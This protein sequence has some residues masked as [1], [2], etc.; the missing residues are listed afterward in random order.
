M[1]HSQKLLLSIGLTAGLGLGAANTAFAS[2]IG[3]TTLSTQNSQFLDANTGVELAEGADVTIKSHNTS[4]NQNVFHSVYGIDAQAG[5]ALVAGTPVD[6][7]QACV[8]PAGS[9]AAAGQN[10][11]DQ[12][13]P[14]P[15]TTVARADSQFTSSL[16]PTAPGSINLAKNGLANPNDADVYTVAEGILNETS[17]ASG[18]ATIVGNNTVTMNIV[19]GGTAGDI[20]NVLFVGDLFA[21]A[22][23]ECTAG[24]VNC[25]AEG[26]S[27]LTITVLDQTTGLTVL[28]TTTIASIQA[29]TGIPGQIVNPADINTP[30]AVSFDLI[31]GNDINIVLRQV[32][33][34]SVS[35]EQPVPEPATLGLFGAGLLGLAGMRRR[36]NRA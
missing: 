20:R 5:S 21:A 6:A 16:S 11:W 12:T 7:V 26:T 19:A 24:V 35:V 32:S 9:C 23:A 31:Q 4:A 15:G 13:Y 1:K 27:T 25:S 17:N 18:S 2:A 10:N 30:F 33:S 34:M 3:Y 29:S 8:G 28:P 36:R 22:Y 14:V